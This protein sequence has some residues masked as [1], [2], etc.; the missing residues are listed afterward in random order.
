MESQ[1]QSN[2]AAAPTGS[3]AIA[4]RVLDAA[5][6]FDSYVH[7]ASAV[8]ADVHE[9]ADVAKAIMVSAGYE[10]QQFQEGTI[11]YAALAALQNARFVQGVSDLGQDPGLRRE[12]VA[13]LLSRPDTVLKLPAAPEASAT[14]VTVIGSLGDTVVSAGSAVNKASYT[15]QR[16]AWSRAPIDGP[17]DLLARV[18]RRSATRAALAAADAPTLI[19]NIAAASKLSAGRQVASVTPT[20]TV[21]RGL[22]L[23]ALAVLGAAGDDSAEQLSP[24]LSD[25]TNAQCLKMAKLN[26]NQCLAVAGPH[27]EGMF[28]LGHHGLTETGQCVVTSVGWTGPAPLAP[29]SQSVMVPIAQASEEGSERG[30]VMGASALATA[31]PAPIDRSAAPL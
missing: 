26:L 15:V 7:Q 21:T 8:S 28:C 27:Y 25:A 5:A 12:L 22:A 13:R 30:S 14:I 18:K 20:T 4:H 17:E 31:Q 16:Q 10:P 29:P 6:A 2:A 19:G 11:A 3:V 1:V 23:A 9:G 24:V